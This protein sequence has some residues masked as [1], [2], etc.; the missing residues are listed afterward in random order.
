[1]ATR[2][3]LILNQST[4]R[5]EEL[6]AADTIPGAMI[7]AFA[8]KNAI[9]NGGFGI[10]QRGTS[11]NSSGTTGSRYTAD[12]WSINGGGGGN[13][14]IAANALAVGDYDQVANLDKAL[15]KITVSSD[16]SASHFAVLEQRIENANTFSGQT[17]TV[18]FRAFIPAGGTRYIAIEM[19]QDFRGTSVSAIGSKKYQLLPGWSTITHT[20]TLPSTVG[21]T[22]ELGHNLTLSLWISAGSSWNA[23]S[24]NLGAQPAGDLYITDVQ[25]ELGS[26]RTAFEVRHPAI[27]LEL[28]QRYYEKSYNLS[29][30]PG[31][32]LDRSGEMTFFMYGVNSAA[33]SCGHTIYFRVRKRSTPAI[34]LYSTQT[35]VAG[36]AYSAAPSQDVGANIETVSSAG[37]FIS[38]GPV[39]TNNINL[40]YHFT[41]D[42]EI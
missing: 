17:V 14:S 7:E 11:F 24:D 12:R 1:M 28:C 13:I 20:V 39:T 9:I 2:T 40:H 21:K 23:R 29:A 22:M 18:S 4:A 32:P 41:A 25:V 19:Q 33:Y 10:W 5:V 8:G 31:N 38:M 27:E 36:K 35:G 37:A 16:S 34:T 6:A 42:A 30:T 3:P 15:P 26:T